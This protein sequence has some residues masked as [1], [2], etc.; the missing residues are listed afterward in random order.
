M[1]KVIKILTAFLLFS[2][3]GISAYQDWKTREVMD[4]VWITFFAIGLVINVVNVF[5]A[6]NRLLTIT[7][8]ALTLIIAIS[9]G[10]ILFYLYLWGD[11]DLFVYI[12]ASFITATMPISYFSPHSY[13]ILPFSVSALVNAYFVT[14][15]LPFYLVLQ[16]IYRRFLKGE[17]IFKDLRA[18]MGQKIFAAFVG[19]PVHLEDL[20]T[21]RITFY[22]PLEE[23][24]RD[25]WYLKFHSG[26][27]L[28]EEE[29]AERKIT[30]L[31]ELE[32]DPKFYIWISYNIPF[33]IA[34]MVGFA[35]TAIYGTILFLLWV[36]L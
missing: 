4:W 10:F 13:E 31:K 32:I 29:L 25:A 27:E 11:G 12:S 24:R 30:I 28:R 33:L 8:I 23:K 35:I 1:M 3:L 5:T 6:R 18:S 19:R 14:I 2:F 9:I 26:I 22:T 34:L 36:Q 15:I 7:T 21:G 20:R 17:K 16:N